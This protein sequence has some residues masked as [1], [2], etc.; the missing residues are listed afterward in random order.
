VTCDA[1]REALA[2]GEPSAAETTAIEAHIAVC[3][4]CRAAQAAFARLD[5]LLHDEPMWT[6]PQYFSERVAVRAVEELQHRSGAR[7]VSPEVV[8]MATNTIVV[9]VAAVTGARVFSAVLEPALAQSPL[10]LA[11]CLVCL[12]LLSSVW[13]R[14]L[15]TTA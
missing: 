5:A 3:A 9:G 10:M 4:E 6:P 11:A 15:S 1:C 12:F 7:L 2:A 14:R 8:E 13:L